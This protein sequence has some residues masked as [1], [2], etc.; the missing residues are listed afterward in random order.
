MNLAMHSKELNLGELILAIDVNLEHGGS[1]GLLLPW[2]RMNEFEDLAAKQNFYPTEK[3]FLRQSPNHDYFRV[4]MHLSRNR[5]QYTDE[6]ILN[7]QKE[8][9]GYTDEFVELM[10]D[11]YLRL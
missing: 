9:G 8:D 1:F 3:L 7:L 2:L 11:Y 10:Q 4:V 6:S 5:K